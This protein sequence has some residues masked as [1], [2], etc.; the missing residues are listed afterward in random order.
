MSPE[1]VAPERIVFG[2]DGASPGNFSDP[3]GVAV[4]ADNEIVVADVHNRRVQVFSMEG[5]FLRLFPAALPGTAA[6]SGTED[7]LMYPTDVDIDQQGH[8]WAVGVVSFPSSGVSVVR[9]RDG[10]P[11]AMFAVERAAWYP[12]IAVD[13]RSGRII[14]GAASEVL[15]FQPDGSFDRS[16]KT[17]DSGISYITTDLQGNVI[18]TDISTSVKIYNQAGHRILTFPTNG[19]PLGVCTASRGHIIVGDMARG[20]VEVFTGAGEFVRTAANVTNPWAI[21]VGPTGDLVVTNAYDNIV[22]IFPYRIAFHSK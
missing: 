1:N 14:V 8:V 10:L 21:A 15:M 3:S 18:M 4:S 2:G 19:K 6:V 5:T 9:Y 22:T 13:A 12:K 17:G 7:Q 11:V 20:R 16:F